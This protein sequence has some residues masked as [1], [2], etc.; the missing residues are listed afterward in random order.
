[1]DIDRY[2]SRIGIRKRPPATLAGLT[3]V[4]RAHLLAIP[5]ENI[6]VQLGR[7]VTIERPA[8]FDKL[9]EQK[10]G[11]WCYEMNGILGWALGELGFDVRRST[12]AVMREVSGDSA[13]GNHL[14]LRVE[15]P[16]GLYL[17]DVGFGDGPRNPIRIAPGAFHSDGF[18]FSLRRVDDAWWRFSNDP[19][20]GAPS[21]D[22]NLDPADENLL[23]ERCQ[24]LQT[25]PA[26]VFVQNLVVQRH[27]PHG[28]QI[29]RGRVLRTITASGI[30]DRIVSDADSFERILKDVFALDVPEAAGLWPRIV[31]RHE[32]VTAQKATTA[33]I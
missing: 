6:D 19:R 23:A 27:V 22:F 1:M 20:G 11:G 30:Q 14:V 3:A 5:Y 33:N 2:L 8:I 26:S 12:G 15:L 4:H 9:G 21:F 29:L 32:E 18:D 13:V 16:E 31:A 17:A 10:R 28:L 25:A 7:A 24:Y